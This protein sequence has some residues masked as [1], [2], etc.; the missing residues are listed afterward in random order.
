[1][2]SHKRPGAKTTGQS[3]ALAACLVLLP[4]LA[5]AMSAQAQDRVSRGIG[6][7]S[8][9]EHAVASTGA[10]LYIC[11]PSGFGHMSTCTLRGGKLAGG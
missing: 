8:T 5:S 2:T 9:D 10:A 7:P 1:M 6:S 4:I 11:T 3:A